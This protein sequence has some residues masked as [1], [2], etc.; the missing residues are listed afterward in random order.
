YRL[1]ACQARRMWSFSAMPTIIR[2]STISDRASAA[3]GRQHLRRR[4]RPA[5]SNGRRSLR[6]LLQL[7]DRSVLATA[8]STTPAAATMAPMSMGIYSSTIQWPTLIHRWLV[9]LTSSSCHRRYTMRLTTRSIASPDLVWAAR[10]RRLASTISLAIAGPQGRRYPS[11][12]A[13]LMLA[14]DWTVGRYTL[15]AASMAAERRTY[16]ISMT[17]PPTAGPRVQM[18]R[19]LCTCLVLEPSAASFTLSAVTMAALKCLMCR[20]TTSRLTPG[21]RARQYQRPSPAPAARCLTGNCTSSEAQRRSQPRQLSR[22]SMTQ[23]PIAGALD[24]TWWWHGYGSTEAHSILAV[25]WLLEVTTHLASRSMMM[26][27]WPVAGA[28]GHLPQRRR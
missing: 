15:A 27:S 6:I 7:A 18:R 20:S 5:R 11:P 8:L 4:A 13:C 10:P 12:T 16:S 2:R 23:L 14:R 21:A 17:S 24:Q 1:Q 19:R 9:R 3:A 25:F 26:R 28:A 22:K